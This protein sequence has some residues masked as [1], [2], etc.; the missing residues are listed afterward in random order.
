MELRERH[1]NQVQDSNHR[2]NPE[3]CQSLLAQ[4]HGD[5]SISDGLL[6]RVLSFDDYYQT[7]A[8]ANAVAWIA[9]REDHH[10]QMIVDY[11]KLRIDYTTHSADGLTENDFICAAHIDQLLNNG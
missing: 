3:S 7:M 5:W 6:R 4:L 11:G 8:F 9:N 1:C 2:L 10:P